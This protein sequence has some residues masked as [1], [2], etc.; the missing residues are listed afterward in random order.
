M[1]ADASLTTRI[2]D[3]ET[4]RASAVTSLETNHSTLISTENSLLA[5]LETRENYRHH[6]IVFATSD[7][8]GSNQLIVDGS[9]FYSGFDPSTAGFIQIFETNDSGATYEALV[10]PI[11]INQSTGD[12]TISF[13]SAIAGM[14]VFYT[15]ADDEGAVTV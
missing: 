1:A 9:S 12:V 6:K 10:A 7:L 11:S 14:V 13:E 4:A 2:G 8:N 3:E 5:S 15:F